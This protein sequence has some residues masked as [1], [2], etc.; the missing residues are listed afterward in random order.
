[1]LVTS[2]HDV[3]VEDVG[4]E[5][6]LGSVEGDDEEDVRLGSEVFEE[7]EKLSDSIASVRTTHHLPVQLLTQHFALDEEVEE[8]T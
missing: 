6:L 2:S 3:V 1:M 7:V 5:R 8:V 4:E